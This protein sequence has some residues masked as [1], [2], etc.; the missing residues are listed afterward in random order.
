MLE[1]YIQHGIY[2]GGFLA[3]VITN[4]L[5]HAVLRADSY[6]KANLASYVEYLF[7]NAP[8]TCWGSQENMNTWMAHRGLT[9]YETVKR[10]K[11]SN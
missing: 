1:R 6:N 11:V 4:N 8:S 10:K 7:H 3:A 2:P 9:G 5:T